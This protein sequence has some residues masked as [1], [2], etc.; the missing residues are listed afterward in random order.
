MHGLDFCHG[1]WSSMG[2]G[3]LE[4]IR[5]FGGERIL[6]VHLRDVQGAVPK[7]QE[8]FVEEGN[9]DIFQVIRT[10]KEVG[11]KGFLIPDH[12]PHVVDDT[13]WG[14]RA[15]AYA[16]GYIRAMLEVVERL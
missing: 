3:V 9:S 8:C 16:I 5:Y 6:Y 14:H 7:F 15:R 13:P 11:F 10:L 1:S 4:A 12:V 2:P